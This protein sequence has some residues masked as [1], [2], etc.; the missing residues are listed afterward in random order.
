[1]PTDLLIRQAKR[2]LRRLDAADHG[3]LQ[4]HLRGE[5]IVWDRLRRDFALLGACIRTARNLAP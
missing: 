4:Y 5:A 3:R 2:T 1:M